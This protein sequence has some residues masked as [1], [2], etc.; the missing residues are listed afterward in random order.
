[1]SMTKEVLG[2]LKTIFKRRWKCYVRSKTIA[3]NTNWTT[4]AGLQ[5]YNVLQFIVL[6]GHYMSWYFLKDSWRRRG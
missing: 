1:M 2:C 3:T 4:C 5:N 6:P